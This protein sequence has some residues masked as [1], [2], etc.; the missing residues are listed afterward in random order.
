MK[1]WKK[2]KVFITGGTGNIGQYVTK[3]FSEAG[4]EC[5]VYTRT[6]GRVPGI[7]A[8]RGVTEVQGHLSDFDKMEAALAGCD[9]VIH[10]ALGWGC[11]PLSMLLNDTRVSVFLM[12]AAEKA[13]V[14]QFIYTSSTA[15]IGNM[16]GD[17]DEE[18]LRIPDDLYGA[19][20]GAT[21]VFLLGFRQYYATQG[22]RSEPVKMQRNIIRPGYTFS[23]PAFPGGASQS[24]TRF[25]DIAR[26]VL[27]NEEIRLGEHDGTQFMSSRQIAEVYLRLAESD[28]NEEIILAMGSVHTSWADIARMALEI[29]P[30]ST[31][32]LV[33]SPQDPPTWQYKT[34]KQQRLFGLKYDATP[35]LR[36]HMQWN[37]DRARKILA[38]EDVAKHTHE[39]S[40]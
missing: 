32:K 38:G 23:N 12:E 30:E 33:L 21:E 11:E 2:M 9:V 4:H 14:K 27:K 26:A 18:S 34:D 5:V 22:G 35:E 39:Y 36:E 6:P 37:I 3:A 7:A 19:T 31:S 29:V 25:A 20:K 40:D 10:I 1:G 28:L 15:A 13:G 17:V 8:L 24:D 16:R